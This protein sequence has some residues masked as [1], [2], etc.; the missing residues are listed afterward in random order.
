MKNKYIKSPLNYMGGK[1]KLLP[2]LTTLFPKNIDKFIDLF[3]GG[4]NIGINVEAKEIICNDIE[5][6]IIDLLNK[7]KITKSS[8]ILQY[9]YETINKYELSQ[10]ERYGYEYYNTNSSDGVAK[11]NKDKY[12]KL[13]ND[14]NDDTSNTLLFYI[15]LIFAFSNQIRFNS[16]G[17]FNMPVN[18]RDFNSNIRKNTVQ[19]IDKLKELNIRFTNCN[20]NK[21]E[22]DSLTENDFVYC[23]PPYYNSTATYNENGRW[24]QD[25]ERILLHTLDKLN[26]RGIKFALSNNLKYDNPLLDEWKD[27]YNTHYING[28]YSNC[29]YQK[30]DKSKDIEVL[31]TNY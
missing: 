18:K 16:K 24:T 29:N 3:T 21:F 19:F 23:D 22:F 6:H 27:K 7:F 15:V 31:I 25:D 28:D 12:I 14:Y 20:F 13:R 10:T 5:S 4:C 11:Y 17:K 1:Y 8:D 30:K 9:I 2:Q 26:E